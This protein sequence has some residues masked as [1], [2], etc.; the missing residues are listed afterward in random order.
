MSETKQQLL[1]HL[2]V[3]MGGTVAEEIIGGKLQVTSGASN[4]LERVYI[5]WVVY[6]P[7]S[8]H[9]L[10]IQATSI[11]RHMVTR[12]GMSSVIGPV[13]YASLV[14]SRS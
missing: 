2:D 9:V 14:R 11:A 10:Y 4:D 1:A 5:L 13:S 7:F 3:C 12:C 8:S 6:I